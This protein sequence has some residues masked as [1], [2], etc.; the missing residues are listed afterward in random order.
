[1]VSVGHDPDSATW[2]VLELVQPTQSVSIGSPMR[3]IGGQRTLLANSEAS[4][5]SNAFLSTLRKD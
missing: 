2:A 3:F 4:V 1:M 5:G